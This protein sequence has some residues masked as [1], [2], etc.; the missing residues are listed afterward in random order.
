[1]EDAAG[2]F[3]YKI[4]I[5][6]IGRIVGESAVAERSTRNRRHGMRAAKGAGFTI[7]VG[8]AGVGLRLDVTQRVVGNIDD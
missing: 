8:V 5:R 6:A 2:V 7:I 1:L 3:L 4:T